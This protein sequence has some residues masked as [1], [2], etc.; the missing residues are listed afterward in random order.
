MRWF[1]LVYLVAAAITLFLIV[2][3]VRV[4]LEFS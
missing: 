1:A 4:I 2:Q 3:V